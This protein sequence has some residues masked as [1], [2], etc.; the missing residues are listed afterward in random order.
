MPGGGGGELGKT[1]MTLK[2]KKE[3]DI[4]GISNLELYNT[5]KPNYPQL[6]E[7][8]LQGIEK[9]RSGSC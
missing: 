9:R 6:A 7:M 2:S 4:A 3:R 5:L 1:V 8:L